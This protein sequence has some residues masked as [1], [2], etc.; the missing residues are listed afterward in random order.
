MTIKFVERSGMF[1][2]AIITTAPTKSLITSSV[3]PS[4]NALIDLLLPNFL[5]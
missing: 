1:P 5:K 2:E 4:T 3:L